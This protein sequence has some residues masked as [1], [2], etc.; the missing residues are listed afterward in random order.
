MYYGDGDLTFAA[1][2]GALDVVVHELTH[3][4]TQYTW[5]GI[6]AGESGALNEAFS[7]IMATGAEFFHEPAG[8]GRQRADYFLGEDLSFAFDPPRLAVRSMEDPALF[9][10][11]VIEGCDP[12]HYSLRYRGSRDNGGVHHNSAIANQAFYLLVEGGMNRT[13]GLAVAGLGGAR[14]GDAERIFYR[15]FTAYLTP[16]A[17]FADARAATIRAA[18]R[19]V[20][21]G[22]GGRGAGGLVGGGG[23][24]SRW[25]P[26]ALLVLGGVLLA[27]PAPAGET[28]RVW[29]SIGGGAVLGSVDWTGASTWEAYRETAELEAAYEAGPG[30]ALEAAVGVRVTR[31]FGVRAAFGLVRPGRRRP[32]PRAHPPSLLLRP[33]PR[34]RRAGLGAGVPPVGRATSTWSGG[35]WW[36]PSRSPS[37][38]AW[39]WPASRPTWSSGWSS[40]TQFPFE[41]V[42]FSSAVTESVRTDASVGWSAGAAVSYALSSRFGLGVQAR[43]TRVPVELGLEGTPAARIDAGGLQLTATLSVGF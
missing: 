26:A 7:D 22:R 30:P 42:S 25:R 6:Y 24:V 36:G 19:A 4:V 23:R 38:G 15:A 27:A 16:S 33:A 5:D 35:P 32:D 17:T 3:G 29:L 2:S 10:S 39:P 12:D 40:T 20:R 37:S 18:R 34:A 11:E 41:S 28:R 21:L 43:Y 31:R 8:H 13:S 1:F 9:C 14:R